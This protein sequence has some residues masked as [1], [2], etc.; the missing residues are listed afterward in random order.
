VVGRVVARARGRT[1]NGAEFDALKAEP[2]G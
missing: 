1:V 2:V